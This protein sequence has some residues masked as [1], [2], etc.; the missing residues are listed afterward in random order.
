M[1]KYFSIF[2]VCLFSG[3]ASDKTVDLWA[4]KDVALSHEVLYIDSLKIGMF[5]P[6]AV[7]DSTM[8]VCH[9]Q[10]P[11]TYSLWK[12]KED[13]LFFRDEFIFRGEG[14]YEMIIPKMY[15]DYGQERLL[16]FAPY[17]GENKAFYMDLTHPERITDKS[18]WQTFYWRDQKNSPRSLCPVDTTVFLAMSSK[19]DENMFGKFDMKHNV[20]APLDYPYPSVKTDAGTSFKAKAFAGVLYRHPNRSRFVYSNA[21]WGRYAFV[22]DLN[23]DRVENIALLSDVLP[24]YGVA[25]DGLNISYDKRLPYC[26][27]VQAGEK[28]IYM[29]YNDF[30]LDDFRKDKRI[31]GLTMNYY[32]HVLVFD[33]EGS[34]VKRLNLDIPIWGFC[35][36]RGED[37]IYAITDRI[38]EDNETIVRFKI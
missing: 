8:I 30:T 21:S 16:V 32:K 27:K 20:L 6:E 15:V 17:N 5:A 2:F 23:G 14:P 1:K 35:V 37:Y 29:M 11:N 22:F 10:C 31:D 26:Y 24:Q 34:P 9:V 38:V 18:H 36:D 13:S 7:F 28:H 33:W 3:C 25:R 12:L 19:L 4:D